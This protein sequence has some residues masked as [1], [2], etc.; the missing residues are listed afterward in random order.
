MIKKVALMKRNEAGQWMYKLI[1]I[2][3]SGEWHIA[4]DWQYGPFEFEECKA[5]VWGRYGT[6]WKIEV[7]AS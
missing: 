2:A 6:D 5:Q 4:A 3:E 1:R 7:V